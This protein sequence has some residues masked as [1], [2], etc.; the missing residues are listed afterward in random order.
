MI[1]EKLKDWL[2]SWVCWRTLRFLTKAINN[3]LKYN[4]IDF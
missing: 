4:L 3:T 1:V 2:K